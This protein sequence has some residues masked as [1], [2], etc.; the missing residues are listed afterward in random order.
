MYVLGCYN[1][2]TSKGMLGLQQVERQM[3][4]LLS[5]AVYHLFSIFFSPSL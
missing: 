1:G 4:G 3:D 5:R 2:K